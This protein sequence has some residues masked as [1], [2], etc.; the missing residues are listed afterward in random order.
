MR[1]QQG[2]LFASGDGGVLVEFP[3]ERLWRVRQFSAHGYHR[4]CVIWGHVFSRDGNRFP[5]GCSYG[6]WS[7]FILL[8]CHMK[9][10]SHKQFNVMV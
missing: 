10:L 9:D 1:Q 5:V 7:R 8:I 6:G 2:N 3:R 4:E